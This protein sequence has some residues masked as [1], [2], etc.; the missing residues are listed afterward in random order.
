MTRIVIESMEW[1]RVHV[2]LA[3]RLIDPTLTAT[4]GSDWRFFVENPVSQQ[5]I[6]LPD[7]HF[8]GAAFTLAFNAMQIDDLYP[9]LSG[10]WN[11]CLRP[12]GMG[13]SPIPVD[14]AEEMVIPAKHYGGLFTTEGYQYWMLPVA[15]AETDQFRLAVS[16]RTASKGLT[17]H[18][19]SRVLARNST[20][21]RKIR[22][23]AYAALFQTI[24]R[25]IPKNGRRILFTSDSRAMLS[26]N[27]QHIHV[28]MLERGLD[29]EYKLHTSFKASITAKRPLRDKLLFAYYLATAD[30]IL[31]DDYHPMLYRVP[32]GPEVKLIQVWHASG[33]FKTV[34]YSRVGKPGGPSPF[35][36]SHK[37]YTHALV[38][39]THDVP[40]YAEAFGLPEERIVPSGIPRMDVFFDEDYKARTR[41][42]VYADL[43]RLRGKRVILFAPT[44]RG[45]GPSNAFY[46]FD[47]LDLPALHALCL[48]QDAL[49][50]FKMHPFVLE[51][52]RI[53]EEFA[54][55]FIDTT[56]SREI[57]EL[58]LVADLVIT[59]YSSVV[60]EYSTLN[61]PMLFFAYDLEEYVATRDFYEDFETFVPGKIVRTF[62]QVIDA[63]R[64]DDFEFE[65]VAPFAHAHLEHLD[66]G[67]TD[68]VID[69]L[70]LGRDSS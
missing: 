42:A 14:M 15:D 49:V 10:S 51:P 65:K 29:L 40:F 27:L 31:L 59:D 30:V 63:L 57:N 45:S 18:G 6:E 3:G 53:P 43:P 26:G 8:D 55:R 33:A 16:F 24:R 54:D 17:P 64:T 44:F 37:N 46:D 56:L 48:E 60:F 2:C 13:T 52:L 58:L 47:E 12:G 61:R 28:R 70:I 38:S 68:R 1:H 50:V 19:L 22:R 39:S 21:L 20:R 67:S 62:A 5:R 36:K 35:A 25:L 41:E 32:F 9:L 66:S 69:R 11:L 34:G 4:L 7:A 23:A